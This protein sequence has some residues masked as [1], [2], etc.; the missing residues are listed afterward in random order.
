MTGVHSVGA[1]PPER[2]GASAPFEIAE[3]GISYLASFAL[4]CREPKRSPLCRRSSDH[5]SAVN[6]KSGDSRQNDRQHH[7]IVELI[8]CVHGSS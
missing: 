6:L 4:S 7:F 5:R 1:V 3:F 2:R 8:D